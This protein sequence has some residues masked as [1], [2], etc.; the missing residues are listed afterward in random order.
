MSTLKNLD[1]SNDDKIPLLNSNNDETQPETNEDIESHNTAMTKQIGISIPRPNQQ[2]NNN[3]ADR[4]NRNNLKYVALIALV[5][6]NASLV[7]LMR[8][9]KTRA[10]RPQFT[11]STAVVCCE[12][13]KLLACLGVV[14]FEVNTSF[15]AWINHLHSFL[16][17]NFLDTLKVAVPAFIYVIQNN[18][19]YIAVENLPA[20]TFQVSYQ[21]KI[22]TTAIFSISMLGKDINK[23]QWL[24]LLLQYEKNN[25][26]TSQ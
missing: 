18:L 12:T 23:R 19:L 4:N 17:K 24:S 26:I 2:T 11:N 13:L 25:G 16:V 14:F 1:S 22:L 5:A 6:Q 20:A 9:V 21:I 7:L 10:D 3:K 8:Y 15:T